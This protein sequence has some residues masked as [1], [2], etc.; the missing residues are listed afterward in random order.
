MK[1]TK[2]NLVITQII[3]AFSF[4]C[5]FSSCEEKKDTSNSTSFDRKIMLQNYA[6]NFIKP[7]FIDLQSK[8]NAL[9]SS[10]ITFTQTPNS[11]NLTNLQVA[12][13]NAYTAFQSA[14]A[15]NFGAAGED[16]IRKTL[17]EEVATFPVSVTKIEDNIKSNT[18]SLN[19]FSRDNRGFLA[20]DYLI[21]DIQKNNTKI[22]ENFAAQNRKNYLIALTN[23]IKTQIDA[24]VESWNGT[25]RTE[26]INNSGKEA[27]SSTA[28]FYNEFVKSYETLKN[29]KVSLPLGKRAG[30]IK[31]EPDKVEAYYSGKSIKMMREHFTD[32]ENIWYGKTK[33]GLQGVGLKQYLESVENGKTL[34]ASTELQ[35]AAVKKNLALLSE[36]ETFAQQLASAALNDLNTELQKLTRFFKSDMSSLLGITI[37]FLSNDGD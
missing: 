20:I 10:V 4:C 32:I 31:A 27:G 16:G 3:F 26:F 13:E 33:N 25:Y 35:I 23:K 15:Y 18:T 34:V 11:Q 30:Q 28:I 9:Q 29:Y 1:F 5:L 37:T 17:V 12:W 19:D 6:D 21:F 7:A 2:Y 24:V 36:T 14:N 22:I 8:T